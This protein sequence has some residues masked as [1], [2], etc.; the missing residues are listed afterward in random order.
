MAAML[1]ILVPAAGASSRMR[2]RDKLMERIGSETVLARTARLARR[3]APHVVVTIPDGGP[4]SAPRAAI[5]RGTGAEVI[6]ISDYHDGLS[7]SIRAGAQAAAM[8]EGLMILLPDMPE[9]TG[10]D[11]A[12]VI[13]A[14]GRD[15]SHA[16]RG[17]GADGTPGHPVI[18][19]RRLFAELSVLTGDHGARKLL[20]GLPV[21]LVPLPGRHAL[22][23]L[24]TPEDWDNWQAPPG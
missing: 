11:V 22:T 21:Q 9:I 5:L 19:P 17:A 6:A 2:G 15:P 16:A 3:A 7:A 20:E 8:S 10:D 24:D 4:Y 1:T 13:A 14:F 18:L 12:Q 23:D